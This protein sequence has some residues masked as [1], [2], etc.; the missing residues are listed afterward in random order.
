MEKPPSPVAGAQL[1][2]ERQTPARRVLTGVGRPL[3]PVFGTAAPPRLLSGLLKRVA[4]R[5]PD[6]MPQHWLLL[7]VSDRIDVVEGLLLRNAAKV[8]L[9]ALVAGAAAVL[10]QRRRAFA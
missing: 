5:Y 6:H 1:P 2:L 8:S 7:L 10:L 9:A 3:T 4:Y